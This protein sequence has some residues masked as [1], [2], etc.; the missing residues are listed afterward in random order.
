MCN[1]KRKNRYPRRQH[2]RISFNIVLNELQALLPVTGK[3]FDGS[4]CFRR[5]AMLTSTADKDDCLYITSA[6]NWN[7]YPESDCILLAESGF[8]VPEN[9]GGN[10]IVFGSLT[11]EQLCGRISDFFLKI[12][13]WYENM[14]LAVA[15]QNGVQELLTLSENVIG[16]FISVSDSALALVAYTKNIVADDDP[17][18]KSLIENGYHSDYAYNRFKTNNRFELW[19]QSDGL[20]VSTDRNIGVHDIVSKVFKYDR[21]YFMHAVMSCNHHPITPGLL[22]LFGIMCE[23]LE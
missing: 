14:L 15:S 21:T 22:E 6:H 23:V 4:R 5:A 3:D 18:I 7:G 10:T 2:M 19:M 12:S 13:E 1:H 17:I 16:N 8:P 9:L 11:P 20:I